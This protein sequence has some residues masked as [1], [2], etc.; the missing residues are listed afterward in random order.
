MKSFYCRIA[1]CR[2]MFCTLADEAVKLLRAKG[3]Q[4]RKIEVSPLEYELTGE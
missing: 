3:Y 4:A 1:Y 2:G